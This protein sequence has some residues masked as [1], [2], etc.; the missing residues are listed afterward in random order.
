MNPNALS[1]TRFAAAVAIAT[2]CS[3]A[4]DPAATPSPDSGSQTTDSETLPPPGY[5]TLRQDDF[6]VAFQ[7]G[8]VQVKVTPLAESVIRLAAPDTYQRLHGLTASRE[9]RVREQADDAGIQ[10]E[11]SV[12]LVSFFTY[13]RQADYQPTDVQLLSQGKLYRP[14]GIIPLTPA[15]GREQVKQQEAQSALYLFEPGIDLDVLLQVEY[16]GQRS[17]NWASIIRLLQSERARVMSRAGSR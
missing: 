11:P 4:P 6:T 10:G 8:D 2:A 16:G 17:A 9:T 15:W 7:A 12:F 5:G 3:A 13:S 1:I 14:L